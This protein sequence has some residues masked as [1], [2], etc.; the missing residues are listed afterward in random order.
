MKE[1]ADRIQRENQAREAEAAASTASEEDEE[2]MKPEPPSTPQQ[3]T[4]GKKG[5]AALMAA[6]IANV[7]ESPSGRYVKAQRRIRPYS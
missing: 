6:A 5:G 7:S 2:E 1:E 4:T 3:P